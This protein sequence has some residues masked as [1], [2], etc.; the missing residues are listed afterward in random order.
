MHIAVCY[1]DI[2]RTN[3]WLLYFSYCNLHIVK[4]DSKPSIKMLQRH[5]IHR[6][7]TKWFELGAELFDEAEEYKLD[8]IETTH[9][10]NVTKCCHEMFR[11]WLRTDINATWSQVVEALKS[12]GVELGPIAADLEKNLIIGKVAIL[13]T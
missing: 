6:V 1:I 10:N 3:F 13:C 2:I 12:P 5:V 9:V 7:A 8:N 4:A 11:Q